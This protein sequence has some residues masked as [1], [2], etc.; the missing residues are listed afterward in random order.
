VP[1]PCIG[2]THKIPLAIHSLVK[3]AL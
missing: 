1:D 3:S 2:I